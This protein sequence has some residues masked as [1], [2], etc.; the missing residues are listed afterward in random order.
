MTSGKTKNGDWG[1]HSMTAPLRR[2]LVSRPVP[3]NGHVSWEAFGYHRPIHHE[4]ALAEHD[5]LCHALTEQGCEVVSISLP[6]AALQDGIFPFDPVITTDA[7]V[8]LCRMGKALRSGEPAALEAALDEL[9]IPVVGRIE[10]PGT[11][12]GGDCLWLDERTLVVGQGYR[13]NAEGI[14]QLSA[15]LGP[16]G[17]TVV[18]VDLPYWH[19]P[20]ECLHLLSLIS[21]VDS[22]LAAVYLPL[23]PVALVQML[24]ERGVS[25][26]EVPD[27]EFP[28]QG[29]NVLATGPRRC[30]I[31]RENTVTAE[32]L[33]AAGCD[34]TALTG[35]EISHNRG[36]GPTCLTRPL[37]REM[38]RCP[39]QPTGPSRPSSS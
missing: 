22:D 34:V 4:Q 39:G 10:A 24:E 9:G 25:L 8:I 26:V 13:T 28:T 32:R 5:A 37:W 33:R 11:V 27:E 7:G 35:D 21:L 17:V 1:G 18:P 6:D 30:I 29:P 16:Q 20:G 12:E 36:G 19:G 2:V 38:Q 15:L 14:R 31:L 23:L 3:P